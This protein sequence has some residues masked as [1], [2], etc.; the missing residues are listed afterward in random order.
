MLYYIGVILVELPVANLLEHYKH[1]LRR[2]CGRDASVSP[3]PTLQ[4]LSQQVERECPRN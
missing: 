4:P 2:F 1:S 3:W